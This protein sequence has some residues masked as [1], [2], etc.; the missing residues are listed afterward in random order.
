VVHVEMNTNPAE[1]V[2][3]VVARSTQ[4]SLTFNLPTPEGWSPR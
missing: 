1:P 2:R 4:A 3:M